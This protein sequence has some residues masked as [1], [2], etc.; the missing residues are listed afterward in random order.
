[1]LRTFVQT[2]IDRLKKVV[3]GCEVIN[4]RQGISG[5][6]MPPE[7]VVINRIRELGLQ[8]DIE[9]LLNARGIV[10]PRLQWPGSTL[11]HSRVE[12]YSKGNL[13]FLLVRTSRGSI[14]HKTIARNTRN[15]WINGT[16]IILSA[17]A[18]D[19]KCNSIIQRYSKDFGQEL[20]IGTAIVSG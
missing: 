5:T 13:T 2:E 12:D 10:K 15:N 18:S 9:G 7:K 3:S 1:M 17:G 14:I 6:Y 20:K 19:S 11:L 4:M 16:Q 8:K